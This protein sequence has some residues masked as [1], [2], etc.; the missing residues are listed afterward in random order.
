LQ[1][2]I[3]K[4]FGITASLKGGHAGV[5]DVA[6]DGQR[7]YSKDETFRFPTHEEIFARIRAHQ[8]G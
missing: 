3:K 8:G 2:A 7:V 4:T 5:F 1:E 6:L